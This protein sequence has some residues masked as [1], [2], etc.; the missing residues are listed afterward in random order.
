MFFFKKRDK[1]DILETQNLE[2]TVVEY[3]R[4]GTET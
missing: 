2:N 1:S 3:P 4:K